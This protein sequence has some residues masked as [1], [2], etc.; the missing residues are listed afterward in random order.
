ME[1]KERKFEKMSNLHMDDV[2]DGVY[3]TK[4]GEEIHENKTVKDLGILTSRVS[5]TFHTPKI[6]NEQVLNYCG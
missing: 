1:F 5:H 6:Q 3:I 4:S 2:V